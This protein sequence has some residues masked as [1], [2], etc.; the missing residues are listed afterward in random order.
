LRHATW[1]AIQGLLGAEEWWDAASV[2][3]CDWRPMD[4]TSETDDAFDQTSA[5]AVLAGASD[6]DLPDC[7]QCAAFIDMALTIR[8]EAEREKINAAHDAER[9]TA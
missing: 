9:K 5:R 8:A 4:D 6:R 1:N 3:A 7:P 2:V